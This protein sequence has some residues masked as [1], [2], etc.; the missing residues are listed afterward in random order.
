MNK[1]TYLY[2]LQGGLIA[3]LLIVFLVF[4]DLLFPFIT[5]K[6]LVFNILMEIL[7]VFWLVFI[8][9]FPAYRPKKNF[10]TFGLLAYFIAILVSCV[11]SVNFGL[12]FWGNAERMLGFFH[13]F[14]FKA[15]LWLFKSPSA[16]YNKIP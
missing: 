12:S 8:W 9:R 16:V 7:L 15:F 13:L 11:I 10:I 4:K 3:S 5:S 6:Q 1:K 2:L 14:H